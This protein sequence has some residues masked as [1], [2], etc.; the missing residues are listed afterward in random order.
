M[1]QRSFG[2]TA[3]ERR[4]PGVLSRSSPPWLHEAATRE[5]LTES[6][7]RRERAR[8]DRA[9]GP[10]SSLTARAG[11]SDVRRRQTSSTWKQY[12]TT[13]G[14]TPKKTSSSVADT[15]TRRLVVTGCH[16]GV[17]VRA[18]DL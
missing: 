12:P 16:D 14:S 9:P 3:A 7:R 10:R 17:G 8:P 5:K 1:H 2:A 18:A 11:Q 13:V 6:A 4:E 15:V